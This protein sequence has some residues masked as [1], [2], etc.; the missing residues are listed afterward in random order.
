MRRPIDL[1]GQRFGRLQ[2]IKFTGSD[3]RGRRWRC[4]C[5]CDRKQV[6]VSGYRLRQGETRSCGCLKA[7]NNLRH[8]AARGREVTPEYR[9]W[10]GMINRC[11]NPNNERYGDYGGRA[12]SVAPR[13]LGENGF[14]N[15][16][17][18][19]GTKPSPWHSIDRIDN[20]KGYTPSNCKWST[21]LEQALNTRRSKQ[22]VAKAK[23]LRAARNRLGWTAKELSKRSG[24]S[25]STIGSFEIGV[26]DPRSAA[27]CKLLVSAGAAYLRVLPQDQKLEAMQKIAREMK[28]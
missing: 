12:I 9:A 1:T 3:K 15:F 23:W 8:G 19:M 6:V 26:S 7:S 4:Q 20:E 22:V 14:Q 27:V 24:V 10:S 2:V 21:R 5:D 18:D 17:D 16:L 25:R 11:E 28:A 13:W